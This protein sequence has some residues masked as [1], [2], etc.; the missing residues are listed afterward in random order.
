[1]ARRHTVLLKTVRFTGWPLFLVVLLFLVTGYVLCGKYGFERLMD[2]R[3][4]LAVHQLFDLMLVGLF[5]VHS[6]PAMYLALWRW[7][8]VR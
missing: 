7:G 8:W 3:K 6:L 5:V 2:Y 4:A 1:M